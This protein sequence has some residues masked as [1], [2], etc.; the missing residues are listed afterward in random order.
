MT[1]ARNAASALLGTVTIVGNTASN[2]VG[3]IDDAVTI[4]NN[5][6]KRHLVLQQDKNVAEL[7]LARTRIVDDTVNE[8]TERRLTIAKR[9]EDPKFAAIYQEA[10]KEVQALFA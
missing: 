5:Y 9:L 1:N 10:H 6:V 2:I 3:T 4:G 7:H 8:I